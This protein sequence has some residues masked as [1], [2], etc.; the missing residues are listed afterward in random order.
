MY[1][2]PIILGLKAHGVADEGGFNGAEFVCGWKTNS[3]EQLFEGVVA[4]E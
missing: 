4:V 3:S 2:D 1:S